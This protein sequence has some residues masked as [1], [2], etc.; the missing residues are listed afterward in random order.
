MLHGKWGFDRK[1]KIVKEE[2]KDIQRR[3]NSRQM[4]W[5]EMQSEGTE[6]GTG[7]RGKTRLRMLEGGQMNEL[8][9]GHIT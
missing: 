4:T 6:H 7:R 2:E 3:E 8:L 9:Q 5:E 1:R